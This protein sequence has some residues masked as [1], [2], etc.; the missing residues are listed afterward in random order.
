MTLVPSFS[1]T[2]RFADRSTAKCRE[3]VA[4]A[5]LKCAAISP[6]GRGRSRSSRRISLRVGSASARNT[7]FATGIAR[8]LAIGLIILL[9][10]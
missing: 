8:L 10:K 1:A 6:D 3:I 5:V 7:A 4:Q 9:A 2:I